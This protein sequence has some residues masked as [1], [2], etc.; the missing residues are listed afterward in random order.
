MQLGDMLVLGHARPRLLKAL[1]VLSA[2]LHEAL[3][4]DHDK[5][6]LGIVRGSCI[7]SSLAARDFLFR[8]GFKD[9]TIRPA[10]AILQRETPDGNIVHA[11]EIGSPSMRFG[12]EARD[13][14]PGWTG[15]MVVTLPSERFLVDTTLYQ[16]KRDAWRELPGMM[17][18]PIIQQEIVGEGGLNMISATTAETEDGGEFR[19]CWLD[20]PRNRL[21]RD[22]K[23]AIRRRRENAVEIMVDRF[24]VF[25]EHVPADDV[26]EEPDGP[27]N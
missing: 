1:A 5:A 24:G 14:G 21:W 11:L 17:A 7:L 10:V 25:E 4:G 26:A 9:V 22:A 12:R 19:I 23:D 27:E 8:V 16:A 3:A 6:M 18:I 20:Q 15:H 2:H 13:L